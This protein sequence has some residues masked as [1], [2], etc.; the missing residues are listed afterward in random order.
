MFD[1]LIFETDSEDLV[2]VTNLED[3]NLLLVWYVLF[4][5]AKDSLREEFSTENDTLGIFLPTIKDC[6]RNRVVTPRGERRDWES[7]PGTWDNSSFSKLC[8]DLV[9]LQEINNKH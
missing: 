6:L 4:V 3:D 1:K 5:F 7:T 2:T 8:R 9:N